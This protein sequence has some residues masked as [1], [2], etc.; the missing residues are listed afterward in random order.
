MPGLVRNLSYALPAPAGL[1]PRLDELRSTATLLAAS[2]SLPVADA[3][4][5]RIP[6]SREIAA[7]DL[8][9]AHSLLRS[10][11]ATTPAAHTL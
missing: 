10:H 11:T 4:A 7:Q 5:P 1:A 3:V 2:S 6:V 8:A 9:A